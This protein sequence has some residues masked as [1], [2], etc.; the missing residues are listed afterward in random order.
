MATKIL[1]LKEFIDT[2]E[3]EKPYDAAIVVLY[4]DKENMRTVIGV[5]YSISQNKLEIG[6]YFKESSIAVPKDYHER[7]MRISLDNIM[8]FKRIE[9]IKK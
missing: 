6:P 8:N 7:K 9:L 1:E 4:N 3:K 2:L 5:P